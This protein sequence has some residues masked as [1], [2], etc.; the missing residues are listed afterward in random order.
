MRKDG[1]TNKMNNSPRRIGFA[2]SNASSG[3]IST[4]QTFLATRRGGLLSSIDDARVFGIWYVLRTSVLEPCIVRA[5]VVSALPPNRNEPKKTKA[6]VK[7]SRSGEYESDDFVETSDSPK[8]FPRFV[9]VFSRQ[10]V[11]GPMQQR[12]ARPGPNVRVKETMPV[13]TGRTESL[14]PANVLAQVPTPRTPTPF[15]GCQQ[16]E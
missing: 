5:G 12:P 2:T 7:S 9:R 1:S 4:A 6:T 10:R 3:G 16:P 13:G 14:L 15:L 11:A 8:W